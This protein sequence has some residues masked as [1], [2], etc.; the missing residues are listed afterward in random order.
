[1]RQYFI[2]VTCEV[3]E[4]RLMLYEYELGYEHV[5]T[6]VFLKLT[7]G[8][9]AAS[10][11]LGMARPMLFAINDYLIHQTPTKLVIGPLPEAETMMLFLVITSYDVGR[12]TPG[13]S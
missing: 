7:T 6:C 13:Q 2:L 1:M 4:W 11:I 9:V 12:Q 5:R 3:A 10:F 8:R